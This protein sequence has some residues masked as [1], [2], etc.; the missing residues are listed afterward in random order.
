MKSAFFTEMVLRS[1][2]VV[3]HGLGQDCSFGNESK[4]DGD[5]DFLESGDL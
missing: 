3:S 2:N 5:L 1:N 4:K